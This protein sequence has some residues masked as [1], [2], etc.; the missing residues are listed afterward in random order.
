MPSRQVVAVSGASAGVGRAIVRAFADEGADVGLIARG[1]TALDAAVSEVEEADGR[2]HA[3][4]ADITDPDALDAAAE[5]IEQRLGPI[6]VWV[7][8]AMVTV[9]GPVWNLSPKEFA[10][11]TDVTYHGSV[12]GTRAA[13]RRM[14]RRGEGTIVQ[15]GSALAYRGIPMQAAYC[16]AKHALVGFLESVR[17][18]L[19]REDSSIHIAHVHLPAINTPQFTWARTKLSKKPQPVPPIFSPKVAARAVVDAAERRRRQVFVGSSTLKTVLAARLAPSL[20]DRYLADAAVEGQLTDKPV[21]D[22]RADN[23]LEPIEEDRG[24]SGPFV[25]EARG[26][27]LSATFGRQKAGILGGLAALGAVVAWALNRRS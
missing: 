21:G 1:E 5:E 15:V 19:L 8:N 11:V 2:A 24:A 13:L 3:V 18:E 4:T 9:Y 6:D 10:R 20:M 12:W 27:S 16:G 7:N 23:L 26:R 25:D 14:R 17:S 22:D